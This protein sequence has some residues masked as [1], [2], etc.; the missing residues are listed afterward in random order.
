MVPI[1]IVV[2]VS[3]VLVVSI[4]STVPMM[5]VCPPVKVDRSGISENIYA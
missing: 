5:I 2:P 4:S 3:I 1:P